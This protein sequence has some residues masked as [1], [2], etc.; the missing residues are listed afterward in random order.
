MKRLTDYKELKEIVIDENS[1]KVDF[2]NSKSDKKSKQ[3]Q[4]F[5]Y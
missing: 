1:Y 2:E 3:K 5:E 4:I